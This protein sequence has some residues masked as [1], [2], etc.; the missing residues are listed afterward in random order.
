MLC[1]E[2]R[3]GSLGD[4]PVVKILMKHS[5]TERSRFAFLSQD[6]GLFSLPDYT[7]KLEKKRKMS[8]E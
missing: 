6:L 2:K 1:T 3:P 7:G 5:L 8:L 4:L